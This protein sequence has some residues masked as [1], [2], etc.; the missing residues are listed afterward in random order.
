[1]IGF[2]KTI[3]GFPFP[4]D[5]IRSRRRI[6]F[7]GIA[8]VVVLW[9]NYWNSFVSLVFLGA[10]VFILRERRKEAA[11]AQSSLAIFFVECVWTRRER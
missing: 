7:C 8:L 5:K 3:F 1:M 2:Q 4:F 6:G 11:F 10:Q 9:T